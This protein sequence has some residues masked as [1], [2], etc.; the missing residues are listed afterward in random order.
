MPDK[1]VLS[2]D[3]SE[4][5]RV[6]ME[7]GNKE[8]ILA[9]NVIPFPVFHYGPQEDGTTSEEYGNKMSFVSYLFIASDLAFAAVQ[10]PKKFFGHF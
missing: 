5:V 7:D 9:N 4:L 3:L 6:A 10:N 1:F 2:A 8:N